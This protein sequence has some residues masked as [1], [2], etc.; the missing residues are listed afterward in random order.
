MKNLLRMNNWLRRSK[1]TKQTKQYNRIEVDITE[2]NVPSGRRWKLSACIVI[3]LLIF[4]FF[5]F[6][7]LS[8]LKEERIS[9]ANWSF[10]RLQTRKST[11]SGTGKF[12]SPNSWLW[13]VEKQTNKQTNTHLLLEDIMNFP[14]LLI[15]VLECPVAHFRGNHPTSVCRVD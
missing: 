14:S 6:F 10:L 8:I 9:S 15:P 13:F 4:L 7:F 11:M 1:Q 12:N 2:F 3:I 5:F